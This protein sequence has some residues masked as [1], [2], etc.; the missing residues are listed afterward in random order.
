MVAE[1]TTTM[2]N[3]GQTSSGT[4]TRTGVGQYLFLLAMQTA[5]A[6]IV[7]VNGVPI[8]RQLTSDFANHQP[9]PGILWWAVAAVGLIQAAYWLR[10]RLQPPR[11]IE[12]LRKTAQ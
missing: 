8:Y 10:V 2:A 7:L 9:R 1:N 4:Q 3:Q 12:P 5:G 6:G 11:P